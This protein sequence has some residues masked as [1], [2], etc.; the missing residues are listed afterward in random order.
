MR[1]TD[2]IYGPITIHNRDIIRLI[3]TKAFRRLAYIKQQGHTY[4]LHEN[5]IH[6]RKEHSIGVYILVN[7]VI[8]HLSM[9]GDISLSEYERKLVST[10]ALL[11]DIGHGPYSHC[12]QQISGEDHGDWTAKYFI[13]KSF[14]DPDIQAVVLQVREDNKRAIRCYEKAGFKKTESYVE[15]HLKMYEMQRVKKCKI[16]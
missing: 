6:T 15:N 10:V 2:P 11:H 14:L 8:E 3:D 4:F 7:K 13:T 9:I 12:F 16:V 1:F 5:A